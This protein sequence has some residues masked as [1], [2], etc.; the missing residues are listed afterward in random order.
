MQVTMSPPYLE[1][2]RPLLI[3]LVQRLREKYTYASVLGVDTSGKK[4]IK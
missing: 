3:K 1:E 2:T 4:N